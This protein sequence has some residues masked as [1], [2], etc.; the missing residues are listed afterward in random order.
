MLEVVKGI[1]APIVI[2]RPFIA[3]ERCSPQRVVMS[4]PFADAAYVTIASS[5]LSG[6][7]NYRLDLMDDKYGN[8]VFIRSSADARFDSLCHIHLANLRSM[9]IR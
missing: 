6:K 7:T 9:A 8:L 5:S 2:T 4:T 3:L 1:N